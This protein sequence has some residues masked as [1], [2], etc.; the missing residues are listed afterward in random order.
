[1][2]QSRESSVQRRQLLYQ[3][4]RLA[5][6]A[7]LGTLSESYRTWG[8]AGCHCQH[9]GAK[10]GPHLHISY[11][12]TKGKT[13]GYYVRQEAEPATRQGVAAW[14]KRQACWRELAELNQERT[15]RR[16]RQSHSRGS[17]A[18]VGFWPGSP[19]CAGWAAWVYKPA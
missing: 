8:R 10:H 12:G 1:M 11:R 3:I 9:G 13:T 4:R 18:G 2:S 7:V 15:L 19:W 5:D 16:A 14:Q 6:L 17:E